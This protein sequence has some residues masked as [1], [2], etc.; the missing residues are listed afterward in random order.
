MKA[1]SWK[2]KKIVLQSGDGYDFEVEE[3][4]ASQMY[5]VKYINTTSTDSDEP[6][7]RLPG[8]TKDT[9]VKL[10]DYC[11]HHVPFYEN[12]DPA[13]LKRL[14]CHLYSHLYTQA[15]VK[16]FDAKFVKQVDPVLL[17]NLIQAAH[18]F[19]IKS[20]MDLTCQA[21][22]NL[23]KTKTFME[24]M[25]EFKID[26][27][28]VQSFA[29]KHV[30]SLPNGLR[31]AIEHFGKSV[32]LDRIL[33]QRR[34]EMFIKRSDFV[35]TEFSSSIVFPRLSFIDR[36]VKLFNNAIHEL[37]VSTDLG[38]L[39]EV[40]ELIEELVLADPELSGHL[41]SDAVRRLLQILNEYDMNEIQCQV[42]RILSRA[43]F[44]KCKDVMTN[45]AIPLLV[46][47][48]SGDANYQLA[49]ASVMALARLAQSYPGSIKV[50]LANGA[51]DVALKIMKRNLAMYKIT[52]CVAKF[53]AVLCRNGIAPNKTEVARYISEE[54][55]QRKLEGDR[56]IVLACY[57]LQYL[58]YRPN[59]AIGKTSLDMLIDFICEFYDSNNP[60]VAGSALVVVGNL[61]RWANT[62]EQIQCLVLDSKLLGC[63]R[64]VMAY[65]KFKSFRKE[66][67]QIV[68]NIAARSNTLIKDM[69]DEVHLK[70]SLCGL[71]EKDESDVR[72]EA[73][74]AMFNCIY[75]D[76]FRQ[77]DNYSKAGRRRLERHHVP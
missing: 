13:L 49:V 9:L 77:V 6:F 4:V 12:R 39:S 16:T 33:R 57:A 40:T 66:A 73:A 10:I 8:I 60:L 27:K 62:D 26:K 11:R 37:L 34:K 47:H 30:E 69:D 67:C 51:L 1:M 70:E 54:L 31:I 22:V 59:A 72:M 46:E 35:D 17:F 44:D 5:L 56:H 68:S 75:G 29:G 74:W 55:L 15:Y 71:L 3:A 14:D 64:R 23:V 58:T 25:K 53:V 48:M 28:H 7:Y 50:I 20:L 38:K 43:N 42:V 45:D 41:G 2:K 76:K 18:H 61:A 36:R 21:L 19:K 65:C 32:K 52:C 63:L 24:I